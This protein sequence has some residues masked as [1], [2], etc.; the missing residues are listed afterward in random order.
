MRVAKDDQLGQTRSVYRRRSFSNCASLE[1]I[2]VPD[3]VTDMESRVF[4]G[5]DQLSSVY[6]GTGLSCIPALTFCDCDSLQCAVLPSNIRQIDPNAFLD[7][8]H[9]KT[10]FLPSSVMTVDY[11]AFE[12]CDNLSDV[13]Y[14]GSLSGWNKIYIDDGNERLKHALFHE[15]TS[16]QD[17]PGYASGFDDKGDADLNGKINMSDV[18]LIQKHI[19]KLI[20]LPP[21]QYNVADADNNGIVNMDDVILLQRLIAGLLK[22]I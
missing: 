2:V 19:A 3:S 22:S 21:L 11:S 10:V 1:R 18:V 16:V 4:L 15:Y 9:L 12:G 14:G 17:V 5:C 8:T 7:C 13:Y 6:L 20:E